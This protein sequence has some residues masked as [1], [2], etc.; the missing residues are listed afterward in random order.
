[1]FSPSSRYS[2]VLDATYE[3]PDGTAVTYKRRRFPVASQNGPFGY[4]HVQPEERVDQLAARTL[5]DPLQFWRLC[6][7]NGV[8]DPFELVENPGRRVRIPLTFVPEPR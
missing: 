1:M 6:D 5:R 4:I 3:A 7:A 2:Q 8:M